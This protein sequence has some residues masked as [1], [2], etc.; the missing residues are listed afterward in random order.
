[1]RARCSVPCSR[2]VWRTVS[3]TT[4]SAVERR[5]HQP[6]QQLQ[7]ARRQRLQQQLRRLQRQLPSDPWTVR[8][9][10]PARASPRELTSA[11][12]P[13]SATV[14]PRAIQNIL[15]AL[16][17]DSV[18]KLR[19]VLLNVWLMMPAVFRKP[20]QRPQQQAQL[21]QRQRQLQ[22]YQP[23]PS[24]CQ[25]QQQDHSLT[26]RTFVSIKEKHK[27]LINV[28]PK[29]FVSARTGRRVTTPCVWMAS[30]SVTPGKSVLRP[31]CARKMKIIAV[32]EI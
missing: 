24:Q 12:L 25:T 2:G 3:W 23:P 16:E 14:R 29:T 5:Q 4:G 18:L 11:A 6:Q 8:R 10:V 19:I 22:Q 27:S 32:T 17:R 7:L 21:Q 26:V 1:M 13:A 28:V 9:S 20:H 31:Q 15:A 30:C